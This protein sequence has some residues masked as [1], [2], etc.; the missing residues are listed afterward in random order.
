MRGT[1][2]WVGKRESEGQNHGLENP[3]DGHEREVD[4]WRYRALACE[5]VRAR[6]GRG[7]NPPLTSDKAPAVKR[8]AEEDLG[9]LRNLLP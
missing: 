6:R 8:E 7:D 4:R 5:L 3:G 2:Q 1:L 9:T